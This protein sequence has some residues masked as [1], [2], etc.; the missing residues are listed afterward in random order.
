MHL[1]EIRSSNKNQL[2]HSGVQYLIKLL[3]WEMSVLPKMIPL[4][5]LRLVRQKVRMSTCTVRSLNPDSLASFEHW[6]ER[7]TWAI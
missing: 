2:F 3:T 1:L 6:T 4:T 7:T 5:A